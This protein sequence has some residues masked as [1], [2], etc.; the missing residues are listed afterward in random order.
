MSRK[1]L[2]LA[3]NVL[4]IFICRVALVFYVER[5]EFEI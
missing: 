3:A 1:S 2:S 4:C 5:I